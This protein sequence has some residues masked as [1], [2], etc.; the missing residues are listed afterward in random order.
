MADFIY[1]S[2]REPSQGG[3]VDS[4]A[5]LREEQTF[6]KL[7]DPLR[8][9]QS[10]RLSYESPRHGLRSGWLP[11]FQTG[12]LHFGTLNVRLNLRMPS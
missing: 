1:Q 4:N 2:G 6:G 12:R 3:T 11:L 9:Q 7:V 10:R 8:G 5:P